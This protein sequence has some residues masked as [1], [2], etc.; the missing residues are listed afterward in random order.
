[1]LPVKSLEMGLPS[2]SRAGPVQDSPPLLWGG[3]VLLWHAFVSERN[4]NLAQT[5][6]F[7]MFIYMH[8]GLICVCGG[9][10]NEAYCC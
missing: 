1:M 8:A 5:A 4:G 2:P 3:F 7:M 10:M 9:V 6:L